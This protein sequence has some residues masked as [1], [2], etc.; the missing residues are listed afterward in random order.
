MG[1]C[2]VV[3]FVTLY[4]LWYFCEYKVGEDV[5]MVMELQPGYLRNATG[6]QISCCVQ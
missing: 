6:H 5:F 1:N 2:S 3:W 4:T